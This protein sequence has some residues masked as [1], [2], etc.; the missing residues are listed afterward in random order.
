MTGERPD[1]L[2][3]PVKLTRGDRLDSWKEIAGYL[4]RDIR[5]VQRWEKEEGL[6]VRRLLH[7][8][9]G[10]VY[11]HHT[12]LD[13]WWASR[14]DQLEPQRGAAPPPA[15]A[16]AKPRWLIWAAAACGLL[17]LAAGAAWLWRTLGPRLGPRTVALTNL[18]GAVFMPA[19]SPDGKEVA[20]TWNGEKQD[21]FDIYLQ[22]TGGSGKPLRLTSAPQFDYDPTF[23]PD[24]RWVAFLRFPV[25]AGGKALSGIFIVPVLRGE[26]HR[27]ATVEVSGAG[28]PLHARRLAWTPDSRKLIAL[29]K[30]SETEPECLWL[31]PL[32]GGEPR[33]L[34]SPPK[35]FLADLKPAVSPDGRSLAFVRSP[36][37]RVADVYVL[38]LSQYL[39]PAG[40]PRPLAAG[41]YPVSE[42]VFTT[43]GRELLYLAQREGALR[44]FRV[45]VSGAHPPRVEGPP[46]QVGANPAIS[47]Q[48]DRIVYS[49]SS[50]DGDIF[51]LELG[52]PGKTPVRL[53]SSLREENF[54]QF[55]PDGRRIAFSSMDTEMSGVW[56]CDSDGANAVELASFQ[57]VW[58]VPR[59]SPDGKEIAVETRLGGNVDVY[60]IPAQRGQPRRVTHH[61]AIDSHPFWSRD[62][63]WIYFASNRTGE[64]QIW[65]T[66]S[67]GPEQ[68]TQVTRRGAILGFESPDGKH[69][70]YAR[71][72][73]N[74]GVWRMPVEG[75]DE[76]QV[77]PSLPTCNGFEVVEDGIYFL[78]ARG[79]LGSLGGFEV[80]RY[81]FPTGKVEVLARCDR[82]GAASIT[83]SPGPGPNR[84]ILFNSEE[85]KDGHL[86]LVEN[87]R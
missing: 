73:G 50:M 37:W 8:K 48:G 10:S 16:P 86:W 13:A 43:D 30:P 82:S 7:Q 65:K 11:A 53:I 59:W 25:F 2:R 49:S 83:V 63:R 85:I 58:G 40:E 42:L 38:P 14:R 54:P 77:I 71:G 12:E 84:R 1:P 67:T 45:P 81:Q 80:R 39:S 60:V 31:F 24:G 29:G 9:R 26:E 41:A 79:P 70:Y 78:A 18:P 47:R 57:S 44:L 62:G 21:N 36:I 34:T 75:G 72:I 35:H 69:L 76:V 5:T 51:Q 56:V 23:S 28:K 66:P 74:T 20:F 27:V 4:K 87:F 52:S 46:L 3:A 33:R 15:V 6:P 61:P 22:V 68:A 19:F 32:E 17:I 64:D 55:S